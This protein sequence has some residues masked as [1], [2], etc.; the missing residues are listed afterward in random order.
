M[1]HRIFPVSRTY[2]Q[3][4]DADLWREGSFFKRSSARYLC[5]SKTKGN[6]FNK[7]LTVSIKNVFTGLPD[8]V[9]HSIIVLSDKSL[10]PEGYS[11]LSRTVD[12]DQKAWRKKQLGY[13]MVNRKTVKQAV[14]DIIVC[15]RLK[16]APEGFILS[17]Y[18]VFKFYAL[19]N[20]IG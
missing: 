4:Q 3:D 7:C 12:S 11:I 9:V 14:T 16:K 5:L 8:F 19:V 17:G 1:S 2:D 18:V 20:H 6:C 13:R 15:S 10:P